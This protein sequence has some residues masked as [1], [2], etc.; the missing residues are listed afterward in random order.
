MLGKQR[1][2]RLEGGVPG[3]LGRLAAEFAAAQPLLLVGV[4]A[5]QAYTL[6][7]EHGTVFMSTTIT[8]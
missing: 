6:G 4:P 3:R 1:G 7:A 8:Q 5:A 2:Q